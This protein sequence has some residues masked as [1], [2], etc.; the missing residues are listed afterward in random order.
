MEH[1]FF[2]C[3]DIRKKIGKQPLL[4]GVTL[5]AQGGTAVGIFAPKSDARTALSQILIG[6]LSPDTG[7]L[8]LDGKAPSSRLVAYAPE[9]CALPRHLS[10]DALVG[11]YED[12]F[13]GFDTERA[14]ALFST[15]GLDTKKPICHLSPA[16]RKIVQIILT[17]CRKAKLYLFEA[18]IVKSNAAQSALLLDIILGTRKP[19]SLLCIVSGAPTLYEGK[20]DAAYFL[21]DGA[22]VAYSATA[23]GEG[24]DDAYRRLF[25]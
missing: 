22:L 1:P 23:E 5:S 14:T 8:T 25:S 24:I 11:L 10:V 15:L 21:S 9:H 18:P 16:T 4:Q 7:S 20:T 12:A 6:V 13:H 3:E 2:L 19:E 17:A